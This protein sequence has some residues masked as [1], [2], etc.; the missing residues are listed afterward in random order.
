M[1]I[2]IELPEGYEVDNENSNL[3]NIVFK[4]IE[5][6]LPMSWEELKEIEGWYV[7]GI[8]STINYAGSCETKNN[9]NKNV[10]PS[11]EEAEACL[12]LSQLLQLRDRWNEGWKPDWV[13]S[14]V[15]KDSIVINC[16]KPIVTQP[17]NWSQPLTFK[18]RELA[19]DFLNA[20]SELIETAKPLL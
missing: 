13:F 1:K 6:K 5:N 7:G 11:K 8:T 16:G 18:T 10:F 15:F 20:F 19:Q 14:N 12:A 3:T 17:T 9:T 4:K 2:E